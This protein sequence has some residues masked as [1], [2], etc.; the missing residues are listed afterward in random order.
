[1][2]EQKSFLGFE[3]KADSV[4]DDG[5]VAL[6]EGYASTFGNI[7][8]GADVVEKG[9]FKKTLRDKKG[10][11]PILLDHDP[12]RPAG[13]NLEGVE[14]DKGLKVKGELHL[15]TEEVRQRYSLIKRAHEIGTKMGLSIGYSVVKDAVEHIEKD[16]LKRTIRRLKEIKLWEYS[17]VTFPMNEL[18]STTAAKAAQFFSAVQNGQ[19]TLEEIE[20]ALAKLKEQKR[21]ADPTPDPALLQSVDRVIQILRT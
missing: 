9:A 13:W 11:V 18:A 21:A 3:F 2:K 19:Y 12:T 5:K 15:N 8:Q 4:E 1:M 20:L 6:F 14:D 17:I 10:I 16:G 7:D